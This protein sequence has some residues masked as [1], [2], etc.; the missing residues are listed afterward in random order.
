MHALPAARHPLGAAE[1]HF[2]MLGGDDRLGG[3]ALPQGAGASPQQMATNKA[4]TTTST[5]PPTRRPP[6]TRRRPHATRHAQATTTPAGW[7]A[8]HV[9]WRH[10][11]AARPARRACTAHA[12]RDMHTLNIRKEHAPTAIPIAFGHTLTPRSAGASLLNVHETFYPTEGVDTMYLKHHQNKRKSGAQP[13][14]RQRAPSMG[15]TAEPIDP[16]M[17]VPMSMAVGDHLRSASAPNLRMHGANSDHLHSVESRRQRVEVTNTTDAHGSSSEDS[18]R[19]NKRFDNDCRRTFS[20]GPRSVPLPESATETSGPSVADTVMAGSGQEHVHSSAVDLPRPPVLNERTHMYQ[21]GADIFD[22]D[23]GHAARHLHRDHSE[24]LRMH[25]SGGEATS[26][27]RL[28][29]TA[30]PIFGVEWSMVAGAGTIA[31]RS[32]SRAA[33]LHDSGAWDRADSAQLL[34]D[35]GAVEASVTMGSPSDSSALARMRNGRWHRGAPSLALPDPHARTPLAARYLD[36]SLTGAARVHDGSADGGILA[37]AM[38]DP[39]FQCNRA[40]A[41][42]VVIARREAE[43]D[44]LRNERLERARHRRSLAPPSGG[45]ALVHSG[46]LNIRRPQPAPPRTLEAVVRAAGMR[47]AA[48]HARA[49]GD[50]PRAKSAPPYRPVAPYEAAYMEEP[51]CC[52]PV[53]TAAESAGE[54]STASAVATIGAATM[55]ATVAAAT[56]V[57]AAQGGRALR[58]RR[59]PSPAGLASSAQERVHYASGEVGRGRRPVTPPPHCRPPYAHPRTEPQRTSPV[60]VQAAAS[61]DGATH[62]DEGHHLHA[63]ATAVVAEAEPALADGAEAFTPVRARASEPPRDARADLAG[64]R[65]AGV[66]SARLARFALAR[67]GLVDALDPGGVN[68]QSEWLMAPPERT[69]RPLRSRSAPP[70]RPRGPLPVPVADAP[71]CSDAAAVAAEAE[72]GGQMPRAHANG[73]ERAFGV[74]SHALAEAKASPKGRR[75]LVGVDQFAARQREA[76]D[77][78]RGQARARD[79]AAVGRGRGPGGG[80]QLQVDS[81]APALPVVAV[82]AAASGSIGHGHGDRDAMREAAQEARPPAAAAAAVRSSV[83][84]THSPA[85]VGDRLPAERIP[86]P[87]RSKT[88]AHAHVRDRPPSG[89]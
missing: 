13:K 26:R 22:A 83:P 58:G 42:S 32:S 49:L 68:A 63:P 76:L 10:A 86:S 74:R 47:S 14:P 41:E 46:P 16:S 19:I 35:E 51:Y 18:G 60:G 59:L 27:R 9:G 71:E 37:A 85:G 39:V 75:S 52:Q 79:D 2:V 17:Y 72:D 67:H 1:I 80:A 64:R 12:S 15:R 36:G 3:D 6:T 7:V 55:A 78:C 48:M 30:S 73:L 82:V 84:A 43:R 25:E 23:A 65:P 38:S 54:V 89:A 62:Q 66:P 50:L 28:E 21:A 8:R 81:G 57:S 56:A 77:F 44:P 11:S 45:G 33:R 53:P 87:R 61:M 34:L 88:H 20:D 31:A 29:R 70:R 40:G 4:P 69:D 5:T 24:G